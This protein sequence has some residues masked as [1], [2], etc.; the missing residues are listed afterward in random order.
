MFLSEL[1]LH[2]DTHDSPEVVW[3]FGFDFEKGHGCLLLLSVVSNANITHEKVGQKLLI[4]RVLSNSC[5]INLTSQ[6]GYKK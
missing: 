4:C 5:F 1:Y 2:K 6:F 3:I